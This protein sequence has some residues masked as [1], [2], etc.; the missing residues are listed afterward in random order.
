MTEASQTLDEQNIPAADTQETQSNPSSN[1]K[2]HQFEFNGNASEYFKI[3]IV[4]IVLTILT[5]G[6]YSAWA[7]VRKNRYFYGNTKICDAS[8]EYTALP[9]QILIGR[10][11][12]VSFLLAAT[13]STNINP[14]FQFLFI[15]IFLLVAPWVV[16]KAMMFRMRN[17]KYC[18]IAFGFNA[19]YKEAFIIFYLLAPLIPLTFGLIFPYFIY[20][21]KKFVVNQS[22]YGQ[23]PFQ[24]T[25]TSGDFYNAYIGAFFIAILVGGLAVLVGTLIPFIMPILFIAVYAYAYAYIHAVT[26]N[27]IMNNSNIDEIEFNSQLAA[28]KLGTIYFTNIIAIAVSIGLLTPWSQIRLAKYKAE[29]LQLETKHDL[30]YFSQKEQ[31]NSKALGEE[32]GEVFDFDIGL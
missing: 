16:T 18:N 23:A 2:I 9:K 1:T 5:L 8:F 10:I 13:V 12:A 6:I 14:L 29:S 25:G 28:V 11:I 26:T 19:N 27:A 30:N 32:I 24:Y 20:R 21:L 7:K 15:L 4:N 17:T 22:R 31:G 3:W